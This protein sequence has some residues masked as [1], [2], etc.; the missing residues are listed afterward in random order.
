MLAV[1]SKANSIT[2]SEFRRL[3]LRWLKCIVSGLLILLILAVCAWTCL[4]H[5]AQQRLNEA[6]AELDRDDPGWRLEDIEAAREQIPEEENSARVIAAAVKL[7]PRRWPPQELADRIATLTPQVRMAPE[8]F[9]RLKQ[10]LDNVQP[11]LKEARKLADMP[12]GRHPLAY[13]PFVMYTALN[14]QAETRRVV[15][16]LYY[17]SLQHDQEQDILSAS[18][19][20]RAALHA[21]ASIGDEPFA[22]SQWIRIDGA[23][24]ACQGIERALAQGEPASRELANLQNLLCKED[25]FP[26]LLV[27]ARGERAM[28]HES[29]VE[30]ERGDVPLTHHFFGR[31]P[32]WEEYVY[33]RFT[34]E[35]FREAHPA[36]LTEMTC[37][38]SI[39]QSP[40][41]EQAPAER[42]L[43][44]RLRALK[45]MDPLVVELIPSFHKVFLASR[46]KHVYLRCTIAA[47]AVERYRQKHKQWPDSLNKLCPQFLSAVPLDPFDGEPLRYRRVADGVVLYS[48]SSD[49]VD[50][51]G[52]LDREHPNQPGVD[53]GVRLWDVDK[54]RQPPRPKPN[55]E[56]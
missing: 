24:L 54:R 6:M 16:L 3:R 38:V 29:F 51:N 53:I 21:A 37:F 52:N 13:Q 42:A 27:A 44:A 2:I 30:I 20:C 34:R 43:D 46:R 56:Q 45:E 10:E 48:V 9:Q 36:L 18:N 31:R 55:P 5:A 25:D 49:T 11:A 50:N 33:G 39:A 28:R 35:K 26:D 40:V 47:L 17:D 12:R 15:N 4:P 32:A 19:A 23:I 8:E 41:P 14:D 22:A 1:D 7:L